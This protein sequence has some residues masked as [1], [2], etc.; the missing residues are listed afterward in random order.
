VKSTIQQTIN[1]FAQGDLK[2]AALDFFKALGYSSNKTGDSDLPKFLPKL[3]H[4]KALVNQWQRS[5]LLFQLV[6]KDLQVNSDLFISTNEAIDDTIIQSYFFATIELNESV[7]S[8]SKLV[9]ITRAINK[10]FD[11]PVFILFKHGNSLTFSI[12]HRRINKTDNDKD[13]LEKVTLLKDIRIENIHRAHLD[14]LTAFSFENLQPQPK[15]FV[16]LHHAWRKVLDSK[17]LNKKFY[18]KLFD[19]Y[20]FALSQV[21]FPQIRPE[22]DKIPHEQHQSESLIRLLTR[23]LFV[24]FMKEKGLINAELFNEKQLKTILKN[25]VGKD[26]NETIYYK[27]ILQNLF[28]ATLNMP[29]DKRKAIEIR[30]T[31]PN[32]NYGNQLV[33][34]YAE[35]FTD[36]QHFVSHFENVP[37]LNGGLFDCLDQRKDKDNSI[38]IRLDGFSTSKKKQPVIADKLFFGEYKAIDLSAAYDNKNKNKVTVYGL[39]D[40]L[41]QYK[42]TV[43][44]NTPTEEDIA[45]DPELLGQVFENLLA[46]YNPETK[47][48]A[49]KQTGS[50][51]TPR[52]IVDYMVDESLCAY[53]S[54]VLS[55]DTKITKSVLLPEITDRS[56]IALAIEENTA[57]TPTIKT[58]TAKAVLLH[59][60]L[61]YSELN[62]PFNEQETNALIQA[63]HN[64]KILDP[65]C[66]SGAFPMGILHKL[67]FVLA[68]LDPKNIAWRELQKQTAM[69]EN[70]QA[71]NLGNHNERAIRI[72]EINDVF[73]FNAS[74]YGRKLYLIENCIHGVDIQPIAVQ[75]S[76]LRFFISLIVDQKSDPEKDN[77]GIRALPNLDFKIVAANTLIAA[78][79][80]GL[81][82]NLLLSDTFFDDFNALSHDYFK[83]S[84]PD[85]KKRLRTKI[86]KL[87]NAK[88][89]DKIK[90]VQRLTGIGKTKDNKIIAHQESDVKL[91]QS[92]PNLFKHEAV[93]FFEPR[94][95]FP[96]IKAGF[97]IV[98]GNPPYIKEY[99]FKA[100]F[101]ELRDSPY[102]Q[103]KMDLWYLFACKNLE[104]TKKKTGLLTFIATNNWTTNT[105]ASKMRS[106]ILNDTTIEKLLDFGSYMIF[107]SADIQTSV[108]IF[109][110]DNSND[111]Y[112]FDFRRLVGDKLT[113]DDTLDLIASRKTVNNELLSPIVSKSNL[114]NK[115]LTFSNNALDD[116]LDKIQKKSNF[117]LDSKT[118]VAQGI[119]PNPD[120]V[121]IRNIK[122]I[123]HLKIEKEK[124]NVGDGVFIIPV[125]FFN[126]IPEIENKYIKPIYE[127]YLVDKYFLGG[128]DKEIIYMTKKNYHNDA[129]NLINHL[130]KFKEIMEERRENIQGKLNFNHL[131]WSRDEY[132][133]KNGAK[134][135]SVRKCAIPAFTYTENE[136]YVMMSFNIIK[137]ERINLKYLTAVFNSKLVAFWLKNKGKMQGRNYQLDKEP[138]LDIP[139]YKP[140]DN[141]QQPFID[142]VDK[143]LVG[144]KSGENTAHLER[145]ID[146]QVYAL[147]G[148]SN[149][150]INIINGVTHF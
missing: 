1:N 100:A 55:S 51:Y 138:L 76:K 71:Y 95:F 103:G 97:D 84:K 98:I 69:R 133:F 148:L 107:E 46:A 113:F 135:L 68:K 3:N 140:D 118:E 120:V 33:Y 74:N 134:I 5:Y 57:I 87:I 22:A 31:F 144:K 126:W 86:E 62:N 127:P 64:L 128:F 47:V 50:F 93:D 141:Q 61:S 105:G 25:F 88:C 83:V 6:D 17:E 114:N 139:I 43:E 42:F 108:M 37:F 150:E 78:P 56:S 115:L 96:Q 104:I 94:Y 122:S 14:I 121:N 12:I 142:L 85:E 16:E 8:R 11:I 81:A 40:I 99:T 23:L 18:G 38:E 35:L 21:E 48:T 9:E 49:R 39:I 112:R 72:Q 131:H 45:L 75:I 32:N 10:D 24:W 146:Q 20:L 2:T 125:G 54:G 123:P 53:F 67:V 70:E 73:D 130:S 132:F 90:A 4:E 26:G 7:Y 60:L 28:F 117:R 15:N 30:S 52:E 58:K 34:R 129:P 65:A 27:A 92:Y 59:D 110:N 111:N 41:Q 109:K 145:E 101:D 77:F 80:D 149:D 136:A 44:E 143:I 102:Y 91:W 137:S 82:D 36:E 119:V 147:Y 79:S 106:K 29:I 66:G 19:W 124:I 89:A 116:I 13:V 63:I